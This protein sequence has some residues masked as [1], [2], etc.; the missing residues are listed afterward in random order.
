MKKVV[1]AC[2]RVL[3]AIVFT[4]S[5]FFNPMTIHAKQATTIKELK[6]KAKQIKD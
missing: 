1:K 6:E 5:Y 2:F 3:I 4:F